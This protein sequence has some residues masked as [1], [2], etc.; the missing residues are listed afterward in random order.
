[1]K[2]LF[3]LNWA[4]PASFAIAEELMI[5]RDI[6]LAAYT[7]SKLHFTGISTKEGVKLIQ[8]AKEE[9]IEITCSVTPYRLLIFL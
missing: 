4:C 1:M 5:A 7:N 8:K 2:G 6:K 9:G 3:L